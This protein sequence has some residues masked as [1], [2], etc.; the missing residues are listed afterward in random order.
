MDHLKTSMEKNVLVLGKDS[1]IDGIR[2]I[3]RIKAMLKK[4]G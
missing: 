2:R 1:D 4:R 3:S